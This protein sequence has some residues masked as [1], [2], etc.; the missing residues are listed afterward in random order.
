MVPRTLLPKKSVPI[1]KKSQ[2]VDIV[3]RNTA[4]F[5]KCW[6]FWNQAEFGRPRG[7]IG[8]IFGHFSVFRHSLLSGKPREGLYQPYTTDADGRHLVGPHQALTGPK[9]ATFGPNQG[10]SGHETSPSDLDFSVFAGFDCL[11]A[12]ERSDMTVTPWI[13]IKNTS[14]GTAS[15]SSAYLFT[16][17][18]NLGIW[19]NR[20]KSLF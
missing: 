10:H 13:Q 8:P 2:I 20:E 6:R 18:A 7:R 9:T 5:Q 19:A 16:I 14:W 4:R 3:G 11:A 15:Y 12:P 17:L 1:N